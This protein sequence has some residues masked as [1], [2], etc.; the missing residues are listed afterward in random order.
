MQQQ[1]MV[2]Y[3]CGNTPLYFRGFTLPLSQLDGTLVLSCSIST[4]DW[5]SFLILAFVFHAY[6]AFVLRPRF[7]QKL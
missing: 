6:P 2:G 1:S 3:P 7:H 4:V 5:L